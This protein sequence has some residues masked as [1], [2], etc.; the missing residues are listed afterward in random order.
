MFNL[1]TNN[2]SL[3]LK[4][5]ETPYKNLYG[6]FLFGSTHFVQ[7]FPP[8]TRSEFIKGPAHIQVY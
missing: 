2:I 1:I 8:T 7:E 6:C 4:T 3:L 5:L